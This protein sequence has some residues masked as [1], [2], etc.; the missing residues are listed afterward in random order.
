MLK[1]RQFVLILGDIVAMF[2]ALFLTLT[3]RYLGNYSSEILD[4]HLV[5]FALI[6]LLWLICFYIFGMY[7]LTGLRQ[8]LDLLRKTL[9]TFAVC[10]ALALAFFYLIPYF[11]ITPK[12]NLLID[13]ALFGLLAFFWRKLFS[14]LF[15]SVYLQKIAFLG[16]TE[17]AQELE[18]E[19]ND[20]PQLGYRSAGFLD[21]AND[22]K[23]EIKEKNIK[24]LI[25]AKD[26]S[27]NQALTER[28]YQ[29]LS[30]KI[31]FWQI[32]KAYEKILQKV[33]LHSLKQEW[34]LKNLSSLN[35]EGYD[36]VKRVFDF[37]LAFLLLVITSP[38]W[39]LIA[40][41]IKIEDG[42]S[43]FYR[44]KRIGKDNKVFTMWKFRSMVEAA[45]KNG[46]EWCK[47]KD[48]RRTRTGKI[49]RRLHFDEFPQM[50]NVLKGDI[51]TT[52]P[53]PER[54][55]FIV[56]LEQEIPH[57]KLRHL[58]KPGFTGWAQTRWIKYARSKEDA[59]EKFQY[60]LYYLKN[61]SFALDLSILLRT[62]QLFFTKG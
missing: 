31:S 7:D 25:I 54:P 17:T 36:K 18:K 10:L 5:P 35:K 56:K 9:K 23:E 1:I 24:L 13:I 62:F 27:Q 52:G 20:N 39:V 43:V 61:R 34:F 26:T 14:L 59:F 3:L 21:E 22:L 33:P 53:R 44:Q 58:I 41:A 49:I 30:L 42:G 12:R 4:A 37:V 8:T 55:E 46:A 32:D 40:I 57:Y 28:L 16:K 38:F 19:L 45:E 11:G 51:S 15:S 47:D 50:I 48:E 2:L 6:Y 60:D 29:L